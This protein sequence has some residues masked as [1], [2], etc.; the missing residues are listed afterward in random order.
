MSTQACRKSQNLQDVLF[1]GGCHPRLENLRDLEHVR[2]VILYV[3]NHPKSQARSPSLD[4]ESSVVEFLGI[5][6]PSPESS[7]RPNVPYPDASGLGLRTGPL[8]TR[9]VRTPREVRATEKGDGATAEGS[10]GNGDGDGSVRVPSISIRS[11]AVISGPES[12]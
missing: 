1:H 8:I 12:V 11:S 5:H 4:V 10:A 6:R 7:C 2:H 3:R 9:H